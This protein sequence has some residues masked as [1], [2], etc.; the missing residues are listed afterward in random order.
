MLKPFNLLLK[1]RHLSHQGFDL[2][3][4]SKKTLAHIRYRARTLNTGSQRVLNSQ[5]IRPLGKDLV[6][7]GG[8]K[9]SSYHRSGYVI[10]NHRVPNCK[11]TG[12]R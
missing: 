4:T 6:V 5:L 2:A 11:R 1:T 10:L 3:S 8:Q 9:I 12:G 7:L